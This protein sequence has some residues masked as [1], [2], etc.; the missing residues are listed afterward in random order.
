MDKNTALDYTL[1]KT[2][3]EKLFATTESSRKRFFMFGIP[4]YNNIGDQAIAYSE[5]KF[6]EH[7]FP[8]I[9]YIEILE[10]ETEKA[11]I[12]IKECIRKKDM[13]G[14]TGGG[15]IGNLYLN[16]ETA[17]RSVF[18]SFPENKTI[19]MTQSAFFEDTPEG[20]KERELSRKAYNKNK[21]L[22][23]CARESQ[24][25]QLLKDTFEADVIH[26]PDIVLSLT[27][28][29]S[30]SEREGIVFLFREDEEKITEDTFIH[31]LMDRLNSRYP[32]KRTDNVMEEKIADGD[33]DQ[34]KESVLPTERDQVFTEK[35][36]EIKS[37]K[38]LVT[39]R[40]HGMIFA[41]ITG[42]P[43]LTFDNSYGK[44]SNSYHDWLKP[45]NFI[46]HTKE[47]DLEKTEQIIERLIDIK[48]EPYDYTN[49]FK[50]LID[51]LS[52][53]E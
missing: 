18:E 28:D 48:A 2:S 44:A 40:L 52:L 16:H 29:T 26:I 7:Y 25:Y 38:L 39:D 53:D 30:A 27:S 33:P 22:T 17:R 13:V 4:T 11:I 45:L 5:K 20:E 8:D 21:H 35:L 42:T 9:D 6:I 10:P 12:E 41:A 24:T 43:C 32:V 36:E 47:L 15:N 34:S 1:G 23:L 46:E 49:D 37:C 3:L 14:F 19:S 31:S 51:V 50:P